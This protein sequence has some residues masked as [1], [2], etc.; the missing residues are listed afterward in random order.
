MRDTLTYKLINS[1]A[2]IKTWFNIHDFI[3]KIL[4]K[5]SLFAYPH[6][7]HYAHAHLIVCYCSL[8]H[9]ELQIYWPIEL[10]LRQITTI[11]QLDLRFVKIDAQNLPLF[12][13][14]CPTQIHPTQLVRMNAQLVQFW[15][16][17]LADRI[18]TS[19]QVSLQLQVLKRL[20]VQ[21]WKS[22]N[23]FDTD[24]IEIEMK[25]GS[26]MNSWNVVDD[27]SLIKLVFIN[28]NQVYF[29]ARGFFDWYQNIEK[30][31]SQ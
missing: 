5:L 13:H 18:Q 8:T 11:L 22:L 4:N 30:L 15:P 7:V 9:V 24:W 21:K 31:W 2:C 12:S 27:R 14:S 29:W 23:V 3:H 20:H 17:R 25:K 6:F 10:H 1:F 16:T 26:E 28:N 19:Y